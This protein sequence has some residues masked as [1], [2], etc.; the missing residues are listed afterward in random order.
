MQY[1]Y[2]DQ[3]SVT[4]PISPVLV[5]ML[6]PHPNLVPVPGHCA[7]AL[8]GMLIR[9]RGAL[10]FVSVC[11]GVTATTSNHSETWV[12]KAWH[13]WNLVQTSARAWVRCL[14][15]T[16]K[17]S[18]RTWVPCSSFCTGNIKMLHLHWCPCPSTEPGHQVWMQPNIQLIINPCY[19][20]FHFKFVSGEF[21]LKVQN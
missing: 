9:R 3:H 19:S 20:I 16:F 1:C 13:W 11:C 2:P 15:T 6:R 10:S 17:E 14:N 8:K 7:I 12:K 5:S 4:S 21:N 18:A